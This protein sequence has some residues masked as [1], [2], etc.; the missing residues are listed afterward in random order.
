MA[1]MLTCGSVLLPLLPTS[2]LLVNS[3]IHDK[4]LLLLFSGS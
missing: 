3:W 1:S 4:L 2:M